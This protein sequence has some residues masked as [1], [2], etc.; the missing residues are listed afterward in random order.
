MSPTEGRLLLPGQFSIRFLLILSL[1]GVGISLPMFCCAQNPPRGRCTFI[2]PQRSDLVGLR[3][4]KPDNKPDVG[5]SLSLIPSAT[6]PSISEI[7]IRASNPPGLW[8]TKRRTRGGR[9]IAVADARNPAVI[10]N[11]T[12]GR[13]NIDP[14]KTRD[15]LLY[16]TDDGGF[17][18][19]NRKFIV[20]VVTKGGQSWTVPVDRDV[21]PPV[22]AND[23]Q[24]GEFPVRMSAYLK[25]ISNFD[26][27][28][29]SSKIAGDDKADGLF[30]LSVEAKDKV[31]TGI[32]I[33]STDGVKSTWDTVPG[34]Q[35]G[36]IGVAYSKDPVKLLNARD[37]SV[38][39]PV[40]K[41]VDL[42]LYV[43]D[44]GS[45]KGGKT[46]YRVSVIFSDGEMNWCPVEKSSRKKDSVEIPTRLPERARVNFLGTLLGYVD[47]DAVGPYSGMRP[48][49]KADAVFLLDIEASPKNVIRGIEI[50]S[51][52]GIS[53]RWGTGGTTPGNWGMGVAYKRTPKAL[54]NRADGSIRLP[55][56]DR[57]Q[58]Y[59]YVADPGNL[60]KSNQPLRMIVHF[61]DG[62]AYQQYVRGTT[63]TVLPRTGDKP[64]AK[65]I[66]TCEFRGFVTDLVNKSTRPRK[67][68][69]L[70]GT[71]LMKLQV[72]SKKLTK[73]EIKTQ[74]GIVRWSSNPRPPVMF[75]GVAVY[76]AIYKLA[77]PKG[78]LLSIPISGRKTLYLYA[79]DNGL[80]SDA[81]SRLTVSATF[82]DKTT[83]S[84]QVIK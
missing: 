74:D 69:Y 80:L 73:V 64:K 53:K 40:E 55:I 43:A 49:G 13:L 36:A 57:T 26:A 3:S 62:S 68:G 20:R 67:D 6:E 22:K 77:N 5:F 60:A 9:F 25:G 84:A 46:K 45:I 23:T 17:S 78:G 72:G 83:L 56:Q 82:D 4:V 47:T 21:G 2:G 37:G 15:L 35:N 59:L 51:L 14:I 66:I 63:T 44:N 31:I 42:N 29:S 54:I 12:G 58:L 71:F 16:V 48:D 30:S 11:K 76:P 38:N 61:A 34:S 24:S 50:Q 41:R 65:G 10:L 79:A 32:E 8:S 70:D 27:V 75:L 7:Q 28:N 39:I 19:I 81:N 52:D 18:K 33:R 1:V